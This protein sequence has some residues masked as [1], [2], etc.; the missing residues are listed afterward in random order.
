MK[1]LLHYIVGS[2]FDERRKGQENIVRESRKEEK[3]TN[4]K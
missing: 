3:R 2:L 4:Y 1:M